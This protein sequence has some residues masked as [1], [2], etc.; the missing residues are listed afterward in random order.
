L[1]VEAKAKVGDRI[2]E[3][4]AVRVIIL[5]SL[6]PEDIFHANISGA[7]KAIWYKSGENLWT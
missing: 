7:V 4:Q 5:E 3:G 6:K 2:E 1:V